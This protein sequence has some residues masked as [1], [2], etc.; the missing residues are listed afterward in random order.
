MLNYAVMNG[1]FSSCRSGFVYEPDATAWGKA[2]FWAGAKAR[3]AQHRPDHK[4]HGDCDDFAILCRDK[5]AE[6]G[7]KSNLVKCFVPGRGFHLV[8][9]ADGWI[10]D[11]LSDSVVSRE[12]LNY[13]WIEECID[14][15]WY[16]I[17]E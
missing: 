15:K 4:L 10:F 2:E 12:L 11:C 14:G 9:S 3:A 6:R 8:A 13:R 17:V 16:E 1:V 7:I 5:L